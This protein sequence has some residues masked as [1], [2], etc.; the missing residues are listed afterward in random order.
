[1]KKEKQKGGIKRISSGLP[2]CH[3]HAAGIDIGDTL[4]CVAISD[5]NG[6]HEVLT[7]TG[8]TCDLHKIV[9]YLKDNQITTVAM[10]STGI[11][12]LPLF[13]LLQE[14]GIDPYLVNASHAKNVT[15]RKKDDT[16]A[17]WLHKLHTCGLLQRS[18]QPENDIRTLRDYTRHRKSLIDMSS[19]TVRRMQK[20]LS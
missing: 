18:F 19:D 1:M 7:T 5:G 15:G 9:N 6:G 14:S 10:E 8:F 13:L 3:P 16:D 11:Y 4:H 20:H 2:V 12:W 17:I